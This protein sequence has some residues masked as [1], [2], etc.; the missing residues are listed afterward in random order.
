[1][2]AFENHYTKIKP[3][4]LLRACST[5]RNRVL[6]FAS[7]N[8][9]SDMYAIGLLNNQQGIMSTLLITRLADGYGTFFPINQG[10]LRNITITA[11]ISAEINRVFLQ[12]H[13]DI[14]NDDIVVDTNSK[15][16]AS[17]LSV[18]YE[19]HHQQFA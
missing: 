19:V 16:L 8:D 6:L 3:A 18:V 2:A 14:W 1:M 15:P 7:V 11:Q 4:E 10:D 9:M 17:I 12:N 13:Y 5:L